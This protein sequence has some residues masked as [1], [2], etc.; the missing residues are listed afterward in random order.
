LRDQG[1][2]LQLHAYTCNVFTDFRQVEDDASHLYQQLCDMLHGE[3]VPSIQDC[4]QDLLLKVVLQPMG[5]I[6]NPVISA[7]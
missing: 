1:L 2:F 7:T 5:E 6:L 4:I 3:G